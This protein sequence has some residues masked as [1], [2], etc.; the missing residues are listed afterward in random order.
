MPLSPSQIVSKSL[1]FS[2]WMKQ[3]LDPPSDRATGNLLKGKGMEDVC[4]SHSLS[5]LVCRTNQPTNQP[6][7]EKMEKFFEVLV[8]LLTPSNLHSWC[9]TERQQK[10]GL[11]G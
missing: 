4:L 11:S 8:F 5:V 3:W 10:E 7:S 2:L 6:T 9:Q 1:S